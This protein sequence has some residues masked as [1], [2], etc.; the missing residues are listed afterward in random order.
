MIGEG[1]AREKG[2]GVLLGDDARKELWRL[3]T[4]E[5]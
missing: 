3:L 2:R 4:W 1:G 5:Q